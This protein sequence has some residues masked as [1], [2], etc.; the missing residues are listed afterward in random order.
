MRRQR[1]DGPGGN[2]K[3]SRVA[4]AALAAL[5]ALGL[6]GI[7]L[8]QSAATAPSSQYDVVPA[9]ADNADVEQIGL[10]QAIERLV[11]ANL[12]VRAARVRVARARIASDAALAP[13]DTVLGAELRAT[14]AAQ[15]TDEGLSSGRSLAERVD[16]GFS[17]ARAFPVGTRLQ[18]ALDLGRARSEFPISSDFFSDTIVRGPNFATSLSATATQ[19]LLR[20]RGRA[21]QLLPQT[22][23]RLDAEAADAAVY[24]AAGT[25]LATLLERA[26]DLRFAHDEA[27]AREEAAGRMSVHLEAALAEVSAGRT[28]AIEVDLVRVRMVAAEEALLLARAAAIEHTVAIRSLW[29]ERTSRALAVGLPDLA[30]LDPADDALCAAASDASPAIRELDA[31]IASARAGLAGPTDATRSQLDV[32][33]GVTVSGLDERID[34]SLGQALSARATTLFALLSWQMPVP[35]RRART[36]LQ[37]AELDL[38]ALHIERERA[39]HGLCTQIETNARSYAVLVERA[40]LAQRRV[41]LA[42]RSADAEAARFA[43]GYSTVQAGLEAVQQL[44]DAA[45]E[46]ARI[47]RDVA[48]ARVAAGLLSGRLQAALLDPAAGD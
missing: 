34:T 28:A 44:E 26:I 23:A 37:R 24:A 13:F 45:L 32:S 6:P 2:P 42:Q 17:A 16:L 27:L 21:I 10:A 38:D 4:G 46:R 3:R 7:V 30:E 47:E 36:D 19:P 41:E 25:A 11:E 39:L 40:A 48:R 15:P 8:A 43:Q 9:S 33:A 29:G 12:D 31:A 14:R 5:T 1:R 35:G 18:L 22:L 20:G